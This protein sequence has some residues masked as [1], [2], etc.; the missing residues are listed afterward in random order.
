MKPG[1]LL[2][3]IEARKLVGHGR[4]RHG[5][6]R[7]KTNAPSRVFITLL[8]AAGPWRQVI[9]LPRVINPRAERYQPACWAR[10]SLYLA[11]L[12]SCLAVG[13]PIRIGVFSLLKPRKLAT[14]RR[15]GDLVSP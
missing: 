12:N 3:F 9:N 14:V 13:R 7:K 15:I 8:W 4:K 6:A 11:S 10:P 5:S 1:I 2:A